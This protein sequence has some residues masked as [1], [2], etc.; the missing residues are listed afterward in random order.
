MK[1]AANYITLL[2][3][4]FAAGMVFTV[5][6]TTAFWVCYVSG[7]LSD[8]LDGAVARGRKCQ[9]QAG[10]RLDSLADLVFAVAL[11]VTVLGHIR[12]PAWI[13]TSGLCI[14]LLRI[15]GYVIGFYKYHTF[16]ALHTWANKVAGALIFAFPVLY[17]LM[18]MTIAGVLVCG[19]AFLSALEEVLIMIRSTTLERD[20]RGLLF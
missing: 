12:L 2:R 16:S 1:N 8:L 7:G 19:A 13:W 5:P 10:A 20:C 11:A 4:F 3:V 14:A 9:S 17:A 18:G 15:S 6:F